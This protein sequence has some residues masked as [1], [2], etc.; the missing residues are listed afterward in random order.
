M[1]DHG[2][3]EDL[4]R[5]FAAAL[6]HHDAAQ[7]RRELLTAGW[8]DALGYDEPSAVAMVFRL[9]GSTRCDAAALD[10]VMTRHLPWLET[11]DDVAIA[12][13][14]TE[15]PRRSGSTHVVLPG[16]REARHVLWPSNLRCDRA[17]IIEL[18]TD[19]SEHVVAGIDEEF[20]LIALS[21]PPSGGSMSLETSGLA[22]TWAAA[23]AAGRVAVAHQM[24]AGANALLQMATSYARAREQFGQPIAAFQAVKHRLAETLVAITSADAAT[25]AAAS[26]QRPATAA[27]AKVL[28]G[29]A[30]AVAAKSCLQVF[31][32]IGF[33]TEHAFHRYFRRNLVL[34]RLLGDHCMI[35]RDLGEQLRRG[36]LDGHRIVE[37]DQEPRIDLLGSA[38]SAGIG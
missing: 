11:M 3:V 27:V 32:G 28:A 8:L 6:D 35:E 9:Q 34:D 5:S 1:I 21:E 23:L 13:P 16:H 17:Q 26:S 29:R 36:A 14:I 18:D 24:T 33:T 38:P 12:H 22:V 37:L 31:G 20:G 2:L 25:V 19:L 30:A 10:D 7:A 15:R 4:H